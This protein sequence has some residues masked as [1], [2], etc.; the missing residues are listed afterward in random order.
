MKICPV[1]EAENKDGAKN[2][3]ICGEPLAIPQAAP[4]A[5][6]AP[7][8]A[9]SAPAA[10]PATA[11]APAAAPVA[12]K[13]PPAGPRWCPIE[14]LE[15]APGSPE[16]QDGYCTCGAELVADRSLVPPD[17][18]PLPAEERE[19]PAQPEAPTPAEPVAPPPPV[20]APTPAPP[21]PKPAGPAIPPPGTW[22]LVVYQNRQP[23]HYHAL[24]HDETL[25]GRT[26]PISGADPQ[27]DLTPFDPDAATSR[28]HAYV[29]RQ[30]GAFTLKP[31]TNSGTQV[32]KELVEMGARRPLADGD[33]IV[34]GGKI[35]LKF[36]QVK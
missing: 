19:L 4:T 26:D 10:V 35:A 9:P 22:C 8:A 11:P 7:A 34:V 17:A 12:A 3:E 15:F 1:C 23:A 36:I 32:G 6:A 31:V 13:P 24:A 25:I 14:G 5:A 28:R 2:C 30:E 21:P 33:V 16:H 27:L 20:A 29:Y 18:K